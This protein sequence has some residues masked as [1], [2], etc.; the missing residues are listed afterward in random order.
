MVEI[1]YFPLGCLPSRNFP[2]PDRCIELAEIRFFDTRRNVHHPCTASR[3]NRRQDTRAI[4]IRRSECPMCFAL[5]PAWAQSLQR[6]R[7]A[8]VHPVVDAIRDV[9]PDPLL[10]CSSKT[11]TN[12]PEADENLWRPAFPYPRELQ[13][14]RAQIEN[15]DRRP[16]P[17][18]AD[19]RQTTAA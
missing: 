4:L 12:L 11:R 5:P 7:T 17:S 8:A 3:G 19:T 10:S 16:L 1:R 18:L 6:A 15:C 2:R 9:Q 14:N 13:T